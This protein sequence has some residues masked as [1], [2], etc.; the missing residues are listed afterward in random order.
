MDIL[1]SLPV[2]LS[3]RILKY[4]TPAGSIRLRLVSKSYH[5]LLTSEEVCRSLSHHFIKR[6]YNA[7]RKLDSWRL[8]YENHVSRRLSYGSGKPSLIEHLPEMWFIS[9]CPET[10]YLAGTPDISSELVQVLDP[11]TY[12][13]KYVFPPTRMPDGS[14]VRGVILLPSFVVVL[15]VSDR[16]YSWNLE[17]RRVYQFEVP[18]IAEKIFTY[19]FGHGSLIAI[20]S[21]DLMM[22]HDVQ[23]EESSSFKSIRADPRI[24]RWRGE[25]V[26]LY[27]SFAIVNAEKR[28]VWIFRK[29]WS[30]NFL[31]PDP[32]AIDSLNLETGEVV[33]GEL[34]SFPELAQHYCEDGLWNLWEPDPLRCQPGPTQHTTNVQTERIFF[35]TRTGA[36]TEETYTII[37]PGSITKFNYCDRLSGP[38][39]R[40]GGLGCFIQNGPSVS[41]WMLDQEPGDRVARACPL[42]LNLP[43][44]YHTTAGCGLYTCLGL[45]DNFVL[46][47]NTIKGILV[48]RFKGIHDN[49][50]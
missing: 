28:V 32:F 6:E 36:L 19:I 33:L 2:E 39:T 50:W 8:H 30:E 48:V 3:I 16:G 12:P 7:A 14:R 18:E 27:R 46:L 41:I 17:T 11:N 31:A 38:F 21:R 13:A 42:D 23:A 4:L 20:A 15:T 10:S 45:S 25:D 22:V 49:D 43:V 9:F 47:Y 1:G 35:D 29:F 37:F 34:R 40:P 44:G 5:H 26:A 24:R